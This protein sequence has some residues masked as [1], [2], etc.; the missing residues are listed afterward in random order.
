MK[1]HLCAGDQLPVPTAMRPFSYITGGE[2]VSGF[3]EFMEQDD[4]VLHRLA[5]ELGQMVDVVGVQLPPIDGLA[6]ASS[7]LW[8][9][10]S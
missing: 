7:R 10:E 6:R 1:P 5:I 4:E 3:S 2:F 8:R 9:P